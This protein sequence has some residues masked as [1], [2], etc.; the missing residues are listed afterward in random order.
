[1]AGLIEDY[2]PGY[3]RL[4]GNIPQAFSRVPLIQAALNLAAREPDHCRR[5]GGRAAGGRGQR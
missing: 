4:A 5:P 2:D 3:R 1:V